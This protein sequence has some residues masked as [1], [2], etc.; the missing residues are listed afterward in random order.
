MAGPIQESGFRGNVGGGY[1]ANANTNLTLIHYLEAHQGTAKFLVAV[2]SS[3]EADAIILAA[4]KPVMTLG[5]FSGSD[6]ILTTNQLAALV[7]SGTVRFFL[8]NDSTGGG[9]GGS[10][11]SAL[12]AWITQHCK[13]V[14]SSQWQSSSTTSSFGGFGGAEQLY[15]YTGAQ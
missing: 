12:I 7:K 4:N 3:N 5:G 11:Q 10:S 2:T 8:I 13:V 1:D 15:E 6:P 14:S 9:P